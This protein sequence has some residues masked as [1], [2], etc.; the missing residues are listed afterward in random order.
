MKRGIRKSLKEKKETKIF[1]LILGAS[2]FILAGFL[3]FSNWEIS[4]K[5]K[6]LL[7]RI[8]SLNQQIQDLET[9]KEDLTQG[10]SKS[11]QADYW[12]ARIRNRGYKKQGEEVVVIKKEGE[13]EEN[14]V[15]S[16]Q[17]FWQNLWRGVRDVFK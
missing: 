15:N 7:G 10:M 14:G 2:L 3:L 8:E 13:K 17:R 6:Q 12:E 5:R 9:K 4:R 16:G 1:S 11:E